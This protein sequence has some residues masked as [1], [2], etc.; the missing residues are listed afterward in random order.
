[1]TYKE[2]KAQAGHLGS[3]TAQLIS[4]VNLCVA[5]NQVACGHYFSDEANAKKQ[6]ALMLMFVHRF[7]RYE[8]LVNAL[9]MLLS[10][11]TEQKL[12]PLNM[13]WQEVRMAKAA[14][15]SANEVEI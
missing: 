14:L 8:A 4:T 11:A 10:A 9:D 2:L 15:A 7:N 6:H 3:G 13:D 1:M 12:N 5:S